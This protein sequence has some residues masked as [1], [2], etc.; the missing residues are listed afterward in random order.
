MTW[1]LLNDIMSKK[2]S[3]H[4]LPTVFK[5]GNQELSDPAQI[6][7]QFCRNQ[8]CAQSSQESSRISK[9]LSFFSLWKFFEFFIF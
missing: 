8:Y 6:A 1:R 4:N 9:V 2:S 3:K 7:E 5:S